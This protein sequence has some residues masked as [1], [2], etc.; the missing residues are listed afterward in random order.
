MYTVYLG[1]HN[2]DGVFSS[3]N[4]GPG[5]IKAPVRLVIRVKK[6]NKNKKFQNFLLI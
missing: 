2:T 3:G 4:L 6:Q 1:I 5:G